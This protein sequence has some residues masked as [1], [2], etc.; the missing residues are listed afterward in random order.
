MMNQRCFVHD[1]AAGCH[2]VHPSDDNDAPDAWWLDR[3]PFDAAEFGGDEDSDGGDDDSDIAVPDLS[4]DPDTHVLTLLNA[5]PSAYKCFTVSLERCRCIGRHE[6]PLAHTFIA[7]PL[8]PV[9]AANSLLTTLQCW[10][11]PL[12]S[13]CAASSC[14]RAARSKISSSSAT[15]TRW[16]ARRV[17][18]H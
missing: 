9:C 16:Y 14:A 7:G 1:A 8:L 12:C 13:T 15:C 3:S 2:V 5:S 18:P 4:V 10:R 6:R 11:R 17:G